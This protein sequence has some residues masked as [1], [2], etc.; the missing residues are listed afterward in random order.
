MNKIKVSF[1]TKEES[2]AES[3]RLTLRMDPVDRLRV[4]L[5]MSELY[6]NLYPPQE[7]EPDQN[8]HIYP[9]ERK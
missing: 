3:I 9:Y 7:P 1:T 5:Q 4:F 8:F 6:L 2:K